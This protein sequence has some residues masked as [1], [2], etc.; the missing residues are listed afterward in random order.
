MSSRPPKC[1]REQWQQ[2]LATKC[3]DPEFIAQNLPCLLPEIGKSV[4]TG[5]AVEVVR[6]R[7]TD[8]MTI[9]Y[10]CPGGSV[11]YAKAYFDGEFGGLV[12]RWQRCLW[13]NGFG[14]GSKEQVP[15]PLGYIAP[16]KMLLMR[17]AS[18]LPVTDLILGGSFGPAKRLMRKTALWL[19]KFHAV[20]VPDLPVESPSERM[21]LLRTAGLFAKVAAACPERTSLLVDLI[22]QWKEVALVTNSAPDLVTLHGQFRPAHVFV[23]RETTV[24]IDLDKLTLS[25]PAKDVARFVHSMTKSCMERGGDLTRI[26]ALAEEFISAYDMYA[27]ENLGNLRYYM[28]LYS[29]KQLGKVWK[30][31]KPADGNQA[32]FGQ[33][34]LAGFQKWA[35]S[36]SSRVSA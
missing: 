34:H 33:M 8:R 22:H 23:Q 2:S 19:A 32:A 5:F 7:V 36:N 24:V 29:L 14:L 27:P 16:E 15:E 25:D 30:N 20:P 9:R 13:E 3:I 1:E 28:A 11:M 17:A 6:A 12:Y 21:E 31:K 10:Q 18:G 4:P 35:Q 26:A